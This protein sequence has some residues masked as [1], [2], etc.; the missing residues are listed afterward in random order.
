[1]PVHACVEPA[2]VPFA[3]E[4]KDI[5][6][7]NAVN[8]PRVP[9]TQR[10]GICPFFNRRLAMAKNVYWLQVQVAVERLRYFLIQSP[11]PGRI[12]LASVGVHKYGVRRIKS[13]NVLNVFVAQVLHELL[14]RL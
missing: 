6:S 14:I 12:D 10:L 9:V 4:F 5:R 1:M 13:K 3:L 7:L 11:Q 2:A 8:L